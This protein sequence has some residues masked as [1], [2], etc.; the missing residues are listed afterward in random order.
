[1]T[2]KKKQQKSAAVR[3]L[4]GLAGG[5]LTFGS[6]LA[7]IR[8]TD[9]YTLAEMARKLGISRANLCD[10][11]KGRKGVGIARAD[12]WARLLGYSPELFV[13]LALQSEIDTARLK[14]RI[15]IKAA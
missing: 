5:P 3:F 7:N 15:E 10:I 9:E 8:E 14:Y 11:E 1:M 12:K 6:M 4:E 2:N 13:R